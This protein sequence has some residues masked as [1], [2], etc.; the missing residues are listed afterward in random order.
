MENKKLNNPYYFQA[1]DN[2]PYYLEEVV[3][4]LNYALS[5][6]DTD[7][8]SLCLMGRLHYEILQDYATARN[9][10][11]MALAADLHAVT[12]YP[13]FSECLLANE[14]LMDAKKLIDFALTLKGVDK[15]LMLRKKATYYELRGKWKKALNCLREAR[16]YARC[17]QEM[18]RLDEQEKLIQRKQGKEDKG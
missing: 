8:A 4:A 6:D 5:Y 16:R 11:E 15:G 14:E 12:V 10:F 18:D 13:Y 9:Y 7:V 2:Y 1:L 17:M 3:T